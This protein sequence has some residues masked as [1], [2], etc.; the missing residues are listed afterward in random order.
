MYP[1]QN[2]EPCQPE[3][4]EVEIPPAPPCDGE[5]CAE[6]VLGPCVRYT[7]PAIPCVG[8]TT[9]MNFNAVVQLLAAKICECCDTPPPPPPACNAPTNV[10]ATKQ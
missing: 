9:G 4:P 10:T 6:V 2:C 8:I 5:P 1:N 3:C 7:G